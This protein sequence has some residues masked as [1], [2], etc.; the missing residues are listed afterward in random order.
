MTIQHFV[1]MI[2]RIE[3]LVL[4]GLAIPFTPWTLVHGEKLVPLMDKLR[5]CM[6]EEIQNAQK[7]LYQREEIIADAQKKARQIMLDAKAQAEG[8]LSESELLKALETEAGRIKKQVMTEIEISKEKAEEE[9]Y[10]IRSQARE[11]AIRIRQGAEEYA[12]QMLEELEENL[13]EYQSMVRSG[14]RYLK[15]LQ[16]DALQEKTPSASV[17]VSTGKH[18]LAMN[19]IEPDYH[20]LPLHEE[21]A[22]TQEPEPQQKRAAVGESAYSQMS[23]D[24][25]VAYHQQ[26]QA[27][28]EKQKARQEFLKQTS[29]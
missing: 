21:E 22:E 27:E 6:P 12:E 16:L 29:L 25:R 2:E 7:L 19:K 1:K 20:L 3:D 18:P 28:M 10:L 15:K 26:R 11:D 17:P 5:D 23:V 8:L 24:D 14:Q 4:T 9:A 13:A